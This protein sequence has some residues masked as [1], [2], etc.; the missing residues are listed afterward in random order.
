[1]P[2][3]K[4]VSAAANHGLSKL[5][6]SVKQGRNV[7]TGRGKAVSRFVPVSGRDPVLDRVRASLLARLSASSLMEP[8]HTLLL[9]SDDGH[10]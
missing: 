8:D 10:V 3:D 7:V 5:L 6:K 1:M 2:S 9:A 4:S